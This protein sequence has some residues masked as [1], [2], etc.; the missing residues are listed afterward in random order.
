MNC[1]TVEFLRHAYFDD[2]LDL[3]SSLDFERHL[4]SCAA[5]SA[6]LDRERSLRTRIA[7]SQL[8]FPT[9]S[10]VRARIASAL[11]ALEPSPDPVSSHWRVRMA[12][13][14][15]SAAAITVIVTAFALAQMP[16][17]E[18]ELAQQ[19]R[20]GHVRS[21]MPGHLSD[22]LSSDRHTVKPWFAGKLSFAPPVGDLSDSGYPLVGGRL[23][24]I[25]GRPMAAIV[26]KRREHVINLFIWPAESARREPTR[27]LRENGYQIVHWGDGGM[28]YWAISDLNADELDEFSKLIEL[29]AASSSR[30][31][32]SDRDPTQK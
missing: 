8:G 5:C 24:Y 17:A 14:A 21:L 16:S 25:D 10:N 27:L 6:R 28:T 26:Y 4:N 23:D 29:I 18:R 22:V 20:D 30:S 19:I 3:V 31:T 11:D 9:P 32:T 13:L 1:E 2:E 7:A 15:S 12:W